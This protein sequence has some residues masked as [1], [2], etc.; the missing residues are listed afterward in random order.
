M[1]KCCPNVSATELMRYGLKALL[2]GGLFLTAGLSAASDQQFLVESS[3]WLDGQPQQVPAMVVRSQEPGFLMPT[4]SDDGIVDGSWRLQVE[5]EPADDPLA[6]TDSLW[7][8]VTV[9]QFADGDWENLADS[10]L[11]VP[12]GEVSTLS[13]SGDDGRH[14]P[15]TAHVYL[16]IRTSR[17]RPAVD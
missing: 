2:T 9:D 17:L 14:D 10:I 15:A 4:E 11:G 5:V 12:E 3:L 13:V 1:W 7:I 6:L 16:E 8:Y